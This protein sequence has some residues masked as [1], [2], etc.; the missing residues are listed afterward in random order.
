MS[1][2]TCSHHK[3]KEKKRSKIKC[4]QKKKKIGKNHAF[5][6]DMRLYPKPLCSPY[7]VSPQFVLRSQVSK[8]ICEVKI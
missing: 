8:K 5:M 4:S 6:E 2:R 3:T 1:L 7:T